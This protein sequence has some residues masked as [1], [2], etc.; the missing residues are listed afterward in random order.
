[1]VLEVIWLMSA[2]LQE[3]IVDHL[4]EKKDERVEVA[5]ETGQTIVRKNV[6]HTGSHLTHLKV[7]VDL[8]HVI[9]I[10]TVTVHDLKVIDHLDLNHVIDIDPNQR[11]EVIQIEGQNIGDHHDHHTAKVIVQVREIT[12]DIQNHRDEKDQMIGR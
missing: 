6:T 8:H 2:G 9:V 5:L 4:I 12:G 1:M 11:K 10:V 7:T 3:R